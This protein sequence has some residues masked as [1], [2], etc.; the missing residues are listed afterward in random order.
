MSIMEAGRTGMKVCC[1]EKGYSR[2]T[3]AWEQLERVLVDRDKAPEGRPSTFGEGDLEPA[4]SSE[5]PFI[6]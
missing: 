4:G 2:A 6:N 1:Q 5:P 3:T